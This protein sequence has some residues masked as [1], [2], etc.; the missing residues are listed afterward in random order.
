MSS[1]YLVTHIYAHIIFPPI[2]PLFVSLLLVSLLK[3]ISAN[4]TSQDLVIDP[5]GL[6]IGF[7]ALTAGA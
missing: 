2:R 4:Q 5:H 7:S 6:E 1:A 3:F